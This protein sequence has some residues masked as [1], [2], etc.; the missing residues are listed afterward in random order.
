MVP[1][2]KYMISVNSFSFSGAAT[3]VGLHR[4]HSETPDEG[5][6]G[7]RISILEQNNSPRSE[8]SR[9]SHGSVLDLEEEFNF[10]SD[11][12]DEVLIDF[13][14]QLADRFIFQTRK[15]SGVT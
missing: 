13:M 8:H 3:D 7:H 6:Y 9:T 5:S 4:R 14:F 1:I 15:H 2:V 10:G 12:S 11:F